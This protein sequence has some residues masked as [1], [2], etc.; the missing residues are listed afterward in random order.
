[1]K[2]KKRQRG[3]GN[4][5]G[6]RLSVGEENEILKGKAKAQS[7]SARGKMTAAGQALPEG[8]VMIG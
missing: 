5:C 8:K 6:C 3:E 1:M 4:P 7:C 2:V